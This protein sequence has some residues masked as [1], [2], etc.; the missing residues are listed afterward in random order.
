V[1]LLDRYG[2]PVSVGDLVELVAEYNED[3]VKVGER[4]G[5]VV[6]IGG[7][8]WEGY[9]HVDF[10]EGYRTAVPSSVVILLMTRMQALAEL[11]AMLPLTQHRRDALMV[12]GVSS[13]TLKEA[14]RHGE[15]LL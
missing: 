5:S 6:A 2:R 13:Q 9:V 15:E 14:Q 12:L 1:E 8:D 10:R 7:G 3:P 11:G 4:R